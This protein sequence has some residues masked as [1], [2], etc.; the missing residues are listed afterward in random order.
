[1]DHVLLFFYRITD[2]MAIN[3]NEVETLRFA[4]NSPTENEQIWWTEIVVKCISRVLM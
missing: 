2:T 4:P 3:N 1:M